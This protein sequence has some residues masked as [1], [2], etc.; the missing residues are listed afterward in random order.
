MNNC[1]A[2]TLLVIDSRYCFLAEIQNYYCR[3]MLA[4]SVAEI[5]RSRT[6]SHCWQTDLVN[7]VDLRDS[8][9]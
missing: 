4:A 7:F 9:Q 2:P 5:L 3:G 1:N 8:G 6:N